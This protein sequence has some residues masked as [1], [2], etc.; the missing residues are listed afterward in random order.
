MRTSRR[1]LFFG[2]A[3]LLPSA[4]WR[5]K[6]VHSD[7]RRMIAD[8][9]ESMRRGGPGHDMPGAVRKFSGMA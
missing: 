8:L 2:V 1:E 4:Q 5:R 6:P 3:S 9:C 7:Y